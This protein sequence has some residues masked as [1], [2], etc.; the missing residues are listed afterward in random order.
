MPPPPKKSIRVQYGENAKRM[1]STGAYMM[2]R[3]QLVDAWNKADK[4]GDDMLNQDELGEVMAALGDAMSE[5][6]L[7]TLYQ[8]ADTGA[9]GKI[10][11]PQFTKAFCDSAA[12]IIA[13]E[14]GE[15]KGPFGL[16]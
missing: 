12:A 11:F 4:D 6:E 5:E 15:K 9:V 1:G 7:S 2:F 14:Q 3:E 10:M 13:G 16:W 8:S